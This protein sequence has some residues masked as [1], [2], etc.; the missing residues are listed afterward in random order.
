[1]D[2]QLA[3]ADIGP[4]VE[5]ALAK[6]AEL[7]VPELVEF[8]RQLLPNA[9]FPVF[10]PFLPLLLVFLLEKPIERVAPNVKRK[11]AEKKIS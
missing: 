7:A 9:S 4:F 8:V 10:L 3:D 11:L 6:F 1:M 5:P 2:V